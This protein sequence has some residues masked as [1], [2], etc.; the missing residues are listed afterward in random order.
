MSIVITRG[1]DIYGGPYQEARFD[2]P[3]CHFEGAFVIRV[4]DATPGCPYRPDLDHP[5]VEGWLPFHTYALWD[6]ERAL[7]QALLDAS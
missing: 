5:E 2:P 7:L 3:Q 4:Y 6:E 1:S